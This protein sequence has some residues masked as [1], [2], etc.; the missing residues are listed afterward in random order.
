MDFDLLV[1]PEDIRPWRRQ[2]FNDD[3]MYAGRQLTPDRST[4]WRR[5]RG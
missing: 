2:E 4:N 1:K 3:F 5:W